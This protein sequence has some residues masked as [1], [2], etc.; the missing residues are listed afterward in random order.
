MPSISTAIAPFGGFW[1]ADTRLDTPSSINRRHL[2]SRLAHLQVVDE[3][4]CCSRFDASDA[5]EYVPPSPSLTHTELDRA[6]KCRDN[7]Q[8]LAP[9][10]KDGG[11]DF[12]AVACGALVILARQRVAAANAGGRGASKTRET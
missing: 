12:T 7:C 5:I 4:Q 8:G 2:D 1:Q 6:S 10:P 3:L 11:A 9:S